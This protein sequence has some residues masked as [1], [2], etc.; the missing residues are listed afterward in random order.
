MVA[1]TQVFSRPAY[2]VLGVTAF[3]VSLLFYLWSSQ[4][5]AL[6]PDG[7]A[8]LPEV[9]F[10]AAALLMALLFGLTLP[11]QIYA[12]RAA[13]AAAGAAGGT[14]LG[15]L[16]G[17]A[18]MSCCAPV[19]LPAVLSLLGFSGT[20]ILGLN[21]LFHRYWLPLATLSIILLAYSLIS[22]G[23]SLEASCKL[24]SGSE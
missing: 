22:T 2:V 21:G 9:P 15:V 24:P 16:A 20:T 18:S 1:L 6:G 11:V 10:I 17:T 13:A 4:V 14:V 19:V 8:V 7:I 23:G 3:A 12:I 5:L